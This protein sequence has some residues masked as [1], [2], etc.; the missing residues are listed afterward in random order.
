MCLLP[1]SGILGLNSAILAYCGILG[2]DC[3]NFL[4]SS[5]VSGLDL[6][7]FGS[8]WGFWPLLAYF[9]NYEPIFEPIYAYFWSIWSGI[10]HVLAF[11]TISVPGLNH[12]WSILGVPAI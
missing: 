11:F 2:L 4:S 3:G 12:F 8:I 10:W 9:G 1:I 5:G 6:G 7:H